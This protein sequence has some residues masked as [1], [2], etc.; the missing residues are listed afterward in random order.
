MSTGSLE[1]D[2]IDLIAAVGLVTLAA[3]ITVVV[4]AGL[5]ERR[6]GRRR[7]LYERRP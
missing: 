1:I 3:V 5:R 2:L 4:L 6:A 7:V